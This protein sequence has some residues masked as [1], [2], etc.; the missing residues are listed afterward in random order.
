M[1]PEV[2]RFVA[3]WVGAAEELALLYAGWT[4]DAVEK[5]I[6]QACENNRTET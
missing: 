2:E 5:N 6:A 4:D 3:Q 1:S